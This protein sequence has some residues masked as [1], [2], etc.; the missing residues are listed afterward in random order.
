MEWL[1]FV[2]EAGA[3]EDCSGHERRKENLTINQ[4][5]N[6]CL[7][8]SKLLRHTNGRTFDLH[9]FRKR[10]PVYMIDLRSNRCSILRSR[11]QYS[12]NRPSWSR[13]LGEFRTTKSDLDGIDNELF[14]L[15]PCPDALRDTEDTDDSSTRKIEETMCDDQCFANN[16]DLLYIL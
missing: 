13:D 2:N 16:T 12:D 10:Q 8:I 9:R 15:P 11:S 7:F 5:F 4:T 14:I 6:R 1:G 3:N